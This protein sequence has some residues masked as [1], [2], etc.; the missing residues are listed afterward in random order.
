MTDKN[1]YNTSEPAVK[2]A[3]GFVARQ[4]SLSS[5]STL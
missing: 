3:G 1:P 2:E 4:V 5:S